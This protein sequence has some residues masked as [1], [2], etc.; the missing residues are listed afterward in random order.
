MLSCALAHAPTRPSCRR[1]SKCPEAKAKFVGPVQQAITGCERLRAIGQRA[2]MPT[3]PLLA[4]IELAALAIA[5]RAGKPW[6]PTAK[7]ASGPAQLD[8]DAHQGIRLPCCR[9]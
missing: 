3:C 9:V 8:V 6:S 4:Q 5:A 1:W 2:A 7:L